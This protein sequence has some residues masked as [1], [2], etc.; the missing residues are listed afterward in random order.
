MRNLAFPTIV[1]PK[2]LQLNS[3]PTFLVNNDAEIHS[4]DQ[5]AIA[6]LEKVILHHRLLPI[7]CHDLLELLDNHSLRHLLF[8]LLIRGNQR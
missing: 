3:R 7:S 6:T 5:P 8:L 2:R 1:G 4:M